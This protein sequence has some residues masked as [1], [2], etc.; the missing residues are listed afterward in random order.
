MQKKKGAELAPFF[1]G[2]TATP[3]GCRPTLTVAMTFRDRASITLIA[4][5]SPSAV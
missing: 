5:E 2:D 3:H 4:S 1:Y